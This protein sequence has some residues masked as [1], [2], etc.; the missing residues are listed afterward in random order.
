MAIRN[1]K[2]AKKTIGKGDPMPAYTAQ[3]GTPSPYPWDIPAMVGNSATKRELEGHFAP[4]FA[5]FRVEFPD[6]WR[7]DE[8]LK[9][10]DG[11]VKARKRGDLAHQ[12]P[13]LMI[14][15]LPND[16]TLGTKELKPTPQ[17]SVADN[18]LALGRIV[19]AISNSPY[20][21]DT[22]ILVLEDDA[23][24][25][26]DHV[27]AHR[28]PALVISK[29]SPA[30]RDGK[31]YVESGFF[32]TVNMIRTVEDLLHLA[33]MN[34]NDA[35]AA[36]MASLFDG[37]GDQPAYKADDR[38]LKNGLLYALTPPKA[39]GAAQSSQLDFSAPDTADNA[40]LNRILW[41]NAMGDE[42]MPAPKHT[43]IPERPGT[44]DRD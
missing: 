13:Q 33:P 12:L 3:P 29:Y 44:G 38:N 26:P 1:A 21:N 5:A 23:Q 11:F 24:D 18:D 7:A 39:K 27:D 4:T 35:L 10:F 9:E 20:W 19:E 34:H 22:A 14:M 15:H 37:R 2:C 25:G 43:V 40:V 31:P 28:S 6:Q 17:A 8:F 32:T 36:P 42:P 41:E 30:P 16:H